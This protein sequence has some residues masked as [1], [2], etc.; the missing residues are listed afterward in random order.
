MPETWET[1]ADPINW[2]FPVAKGHANASL[3]LYNLQKGMEAYTPREWN[4]VGRRMARLASEVFGVTYQFNPTLKKVGRVLQEKKIMTGTLI[5]TSPQDLLGEANQQIAAAVELIGTDPGAARDLLMQTMAAMD[6]QTQPANP[7]APKPPAMGGAGGS[8]A[9]AAG[10]EPEVAKVLEP[11]TPVVPAED[12]IKDAIAKAMA[13]MME[14]I[15]KQQEALAQLQKVQENPAGQIPAGDLAAILNN[16]K[17][18]ENPLLDAM[19]KGDLSKAFQVVGND[20]SKLYEQVN[21]LAVRQLALTGI[22]VSK[23]GIFPSDEPVLGQPQ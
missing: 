20:T 17:P 13:P 9:N 18:E 10:T 2:K 23:Y 3:V 16:M 14:L 7:A 8:V 19:N 1:Y 22:N 15:Q 4:I 12:V 6:T 11:E 5:K 21:D